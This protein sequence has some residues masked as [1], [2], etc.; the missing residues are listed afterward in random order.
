[1]ISADSHVVEP[2]EVLVGLEERFGDDA[3]RCVDHG[4]LKDVMFVPA[5]GTRGLPPA[6]MGIAGYRLDGPLAVDRERT[7]KPDPEDP[8]HP[9][10]AE[11]STGGY[12][13]V[14][15]GIVDPATRLD[16]QELDGVR[17][18][19]LYPSLFFSVFGLPNPDVVAAAF[20]NY[21][22][23]MADY[24]SVDPQRLVGAALLPMHDPAVALA[25]LQKALDRG[26]RTACIP[27]KA[28]ADRPYRDVGYEP[29]W[30]LAED[31]GI[32]LAMHIGTNSFAPRTLRAEGVTAAIDPVGRYAGAA[33]VIQTTVSE[34]ICQGVAARHPDLT[35]IV[36]EFNAGWLPNWLERLDQ[37]WMRDFTAVDTAV[38]RPPSSYW[39]TNFK[40]TIEDD[41][42]AVLSR[43][44]IGVDTILWGND[45]P[46][47][48]STWPCS[49][50]VVDTVME[51][52]STKDRAMMVESNAADLYRI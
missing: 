35:F 51:G 16:D 26:F 45:Y 4:A 3:P 5:T 17:A 48:D 52:V 46:H 22:D 25:E 24:C 33:S 9:A 1:M 7:E 30:A 12:E 49:E 20:A 44:L 42:S 18:E 14:R 10:V 23:W 50:G 19:V 41:R 34:L 28:P 38:D 13:V 37:G 15:K 39:G 21:N 6:R 40:V 32:P 29:V 36:S 47:R 11:L 2:A 8:A 31:A 27:C 43:E